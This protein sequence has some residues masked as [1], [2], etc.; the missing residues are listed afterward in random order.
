MDTVVVFSERG[1]R[2][3]YTSLSSPMIR[4]VFAPV[5]TT[6]STF[7][8]AAINLAIIDCGDKAEA[9]L[10][11]LGQLRRHRPGV[12]VIFVTAVHSEDVVLHAYKLGAREYFRQ[13]FLAEELGAAVAKILGF[14][15]QAPKPGPVAMTNANL[16]ERLRRV[17]EYIEQNLTAPLSL[18]ELA[19]RACT[20]KFHFCRLFKRYTGLTPKQFYICRRIEKAREL[21][22]KNDHTISQVAYRLGFNDVSEFI[23][24]FKK[25]TG[26]TPRG[27]RN[28]R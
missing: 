14:K 12:P 1:A 3:V 11:T 16:P 17:V 5:G 2:S 6:A 9:G 20:S 25:F 21:L 15:R 8:A 7:A 28:S 26:Y 24:Q 13:P 22:D 27:Y 19:D 4:V 10:A 18:G 23:R